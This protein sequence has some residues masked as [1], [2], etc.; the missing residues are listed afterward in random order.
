MPGT[1]TKLATFEYSYKAGSAEI[2]ELNEDDAGWMSY[3]S[4]PLIMVL[5]MGA[6]CF[7]SVRQIGKNKEGKKSSYKTGSSMSSGSG[8][9]GFGGR[10]R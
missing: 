3:V 1:E 8:R 10:R 7:I 5:F 6:A 4:K 9:K 2:K